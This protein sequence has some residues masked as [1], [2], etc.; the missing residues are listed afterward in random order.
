LRRR[1]AQKDA[2]GGGVIWRQS[3]EWIWR[4]QL[5]GFGAIN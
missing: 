2:D 1:G 5:N 3:I 4:N